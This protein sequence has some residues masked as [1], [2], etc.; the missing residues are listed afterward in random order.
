MDNQNRNFTCDLH[1]IINNNLDKNNQNL[2]PKS[3][4]N[5]NTEID[6]NKEHNVTNTNTVE[7]QRTCKKKK[8]KKYKNLISEIISS[9]KKNEQT[10]KEEHLEQ[11]KKSL[12]GGNFKKIDKI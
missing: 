11:L 3:L 10:E 2:S 1:D 8:K 5:K 4:S 7:L 9:N 12:G 6:I